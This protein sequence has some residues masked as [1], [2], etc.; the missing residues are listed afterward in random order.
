MIL[1]TGTISN[2][3]SYVNNCQRNQY[4]YKIPITSLSDVQLYIDIGAIRPDSVQYQLI[5]TCGAIGGSIDIITTSQYIVGKDTN[6]NWYGVFKS[7]TGSSPSCFVIAITLTTNSV[8]KIY[9]SDEYCIENN[10][11]SLTLL[12]GCYGNLDNKLS[13]DCEGIY[14]GTTDAVDAMGDITIVY[15]HQAYLRQ[16]EV[17]L[18]AIKNT[19]KQGRTRNFRT[20]KEKLFQF[21]AEFVPEWYLPEIDSIFYRGEVFVGDIK[22]LIN[23][24]NFEKIE[25]CKRIWKLVS[26]FK[27]SCYQSF[28]CELDPCAPPVETCCDPESITA[29]SVFIDN[30]ITCCDPEIINADI[31]F[32]ETYFIIDFD[33]TILKNNNGD[34]LI[35]Y[36]TLILP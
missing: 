27:E 16:V 4:P 35:W 12:K 22:Y 6:D 2:Y 31:E 15:K 17:T 13:Y 25:D 28:S 11:E 9:F 21:M 18:S 1:G 7:F 10:C 30:T 23:E 3:G 29:T 8:D 5:H 36:P 14:F 32:V 26:T 20:E 33:N 19:F 24:T 34:P